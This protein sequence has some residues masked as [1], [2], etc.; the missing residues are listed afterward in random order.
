[1]DHAGHAC[2]DQANKF[3]VAGSR[4]SDGKALPFCQ[5]RSGDAGR[6]VEAAGAA[7]RK[8]RTTHLKSQPCLPRS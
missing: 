6:A 7:S 8:P 2:M 1:M 4:K 3:E 5:S